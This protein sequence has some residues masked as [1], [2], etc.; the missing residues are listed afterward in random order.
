MMLAGVKD[1]HVHDIATKSLPD[2]VYFVHPSLSIRFKLMFL[3]KEEYRE[4]T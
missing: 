1:E 4:L 2:T 3:N